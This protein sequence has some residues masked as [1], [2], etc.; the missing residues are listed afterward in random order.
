MKRLTIKSQISPP[1]HIRT[2]PRWRC[3]CSV[4]KIE[5]Q[6]IKFRPAHGFDRKTYKHKTANFCTSITRHRWD[7]NSHR[8]MRIASHSPL[9]ADLFDDR[10]YN[11]FNRETTT[12]CLQPM[13]QS[14]PSL[15]FHQSVDCNRFYRSDARPSKMGCASTVYDNLSIKK[16]RTASRYCSVVVIR[17]RLLR[18]KTIEK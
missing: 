5:K 18:W 4:I 16:L 8:D 14:S 10:F 3:C 13:I 12:G 17:V 6:I 1:G 15:P 9:S 11:P 7:I 2:W